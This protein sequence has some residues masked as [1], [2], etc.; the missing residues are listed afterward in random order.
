MQK[1]TINVS[2][3][4]LVFERR[5]NFFQSIW[6]FALNNTILAI[7]IRI[8]LPLLL[9]FIVLAVAFFLLLWAL[10]TVLFVMGI[11]FCFIICFDVLTYFLLWKKSEIYKLESITIE[12]DG[13]IIKHQDDNCSNKILFSAIVRLFYSGGYSYIATGG[14]IFFWRRHC[15][16]EYIKDKQDKGK[17]ILPF[18]IPKLPMLLKIIALRSSLAKTISGKLSLF[19][20]WEKVQTKSGQQELEEEARFGV[21]NPNAPVGKAVLVALV[22]VALISAAYFMFQGVHFLP[23]KTNTP[24]LDGSEEQQDSALYY[25]NEQLGIELN[26]VEINHIIK[27]NRVDNFNDSFSLF[28]QEGKQVLFCTDDKLNMSEQSFLDF[29][30]QS[31][32]CNDGYLN[33][34]NLQGYLVRG[35]REGVGLGFDFENPY[36]G[37]GELPPCGGSILSL[38]EERLYDSYFLLFHN[39]REDFIWCIFDKTDQA[40][41][42]K[43]LATLRLLKSDAID[44]QTYRNE[45]LGFEVRHPLD[46]IEQKKEEGVSFELPPA[47]VYVGG[48]THPSNVYF[49]IKIGLY[50]EYDSLD[51][52]FEEWRA[53]YPNFVND[54]HVSELFPISVGGITFYNYSWIQQMQGEMYL[55]LKDGYLFIISFAL[56]NTE[57]KHPDYNDMR[58][59]EQYAQ[60]QKFL[61][62][63]HFIQA[64]AEQPAEKI[65][66]PSVDVSL[67]DGWHIYQ[68]EKFAFKFYYPGD[69]AAIEY[70]NPGKPYL[71]FI[72]LGPEASIQEGGSSAVAVRNQTAE[73]YVLELQKE[74]IVEGSMPICLG[75]KMATKYYIHSLGVGNIEREVVIAQQGETLFE[76]SLGANQSDNE[77][78]DQMLSTF[79]FLE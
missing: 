7:P 77:T 13:L 45:D 8:D 53:N 69:W 63:F 6:H 41:I 37:F 11:A 71:A 10:Q 64:Q 57:A 58:A 34:N 23:E 38:E 74:F 1:E 26:R 30:A 66:C 14:S 5:K 40:D 25:R 29:R 19:Y 43:I 31:A 9:L 56:D 55:T 79:R 48:N 62:T 65:V 47:I 50:K 28:N 18:D 44:W 75:N 27:N 3:D 72:E 42:E 73:T 36:Q 33:V 46:W 16:I 59:T 70:K 12:K 60:F 4:T 22:I 17:I 51:S 21:I 39:S 68:S 49:Y 61:K 32:I 54:W 76:F 35:I 78:F 20:K 52:Y 2:Q 15:V 67:I 24:L